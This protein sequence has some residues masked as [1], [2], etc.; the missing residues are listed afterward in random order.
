MLYSELRGAILARAHVR[1]GDHLAIAAYSGRS[2]A[3]EHAMA[4][5]AAPCADPNDRDYEAFLAAI[6]VGRI[7]APE[8]LGPAVHSRTPGG[9][10]KGPTAH[11]RPFG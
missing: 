10:G 1:C 6:A 8:E 4:T 5:F 7:E 11:T 3:F 9:A 2:D